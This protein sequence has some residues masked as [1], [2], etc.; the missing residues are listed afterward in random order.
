MPLM[1]SVAWPGDEFLRG[2]R[3]ERDNMKIVAVV[4]PGW[5]DFDEQHRLIGAL[6]LPLNARGVTQV[7]GLIEQLR[8]L[9]DAPEAVLC[10]MAQPATCT[11]EAIAEAFDLTTRKSEE[12]SNLNQGLWQG[13]TTEE[14]GRRMSR[15]FNQWQEAPETICP[16]E[17]EPWENAVDRVRRALKKPLRKFNSLVIVASEPL[18]SL[19]SSVLTGE[20]PELTS[21]FS[22]GLGD[23]QIGVFESSGRDGEFVRVSLNPETEDGETHR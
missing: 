17:G 16:P 21:A 10:G 2:A 14:I 11:A 13:S 1:N 4:R 18:A 19:V 15:V 23:P 6:E 22:G 20:P 9:S 12:L 8:T 7:A 5:T 3:I